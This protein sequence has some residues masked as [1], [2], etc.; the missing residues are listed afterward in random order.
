MPDH[1]HLLIQPLSKASEEYW[2]LS[3]ILHSIKSYTAKQ[4]PKVMPHIGTLWQDSRFDRIIRDEREFLDTWEY[5]RQNPVK[6]DLCSTTEEYPF[7]WQLSTAQPVEQASSLS[8]PPNIL[9]KFEY[10]GQDA[11]ATA[12]TENQHVGQASSLSNPLN[13]SNPPNPSNSSDEFGHLGQDAQA[14]VA[15]LETEKI[16]IVIASAD[17]LLHIN[18]G[19]VDVIV[20]DRLSS[21]YGDK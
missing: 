19:S 15:N 18:D 14:T 17:S 6:A 4:I 7:F 9:D 5:I 11:Q 8:N 2:S 1:V 20:T 13:P 16:S 21:P 3:S 10:L 12:T